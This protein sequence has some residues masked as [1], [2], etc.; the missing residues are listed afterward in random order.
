LPGLWYYTIR[1][2]K[3]NKKMTKVYEKEFT[4]KGQMVSYYNKVSEN[5]KVDT[6]ICGYFHDKN[7][8]MVKWTYKK[9]K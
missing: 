9:N 3:E 4:Y 5:P 6:C 7:S 2:R 1:K 8:Y